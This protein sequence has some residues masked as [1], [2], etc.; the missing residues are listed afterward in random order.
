MGLSNLILADTQVLY[1][2][3]SPVQTFSPGGKVLFNVTN[4]G[5]HGVTWYHNG[6]EIKNS[7]RIIANETQLVIHQAVTSD[8]GVYQL[9]ITSLFLSCNESSRSG[10]WLHLLENLAAYAPVT[11]ILQDNDQ[12]IFYC[13]FICKIMINL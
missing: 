3:D 4:S 9:R 11:F 10:E 6:T 5:L 1:S 8:A 13:T 12:G 7:D 2:G